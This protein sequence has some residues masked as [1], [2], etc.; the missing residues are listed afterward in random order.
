METTTKIFPRSRLQYQPPGQKQRSL[1]KARGQ[2]EGGVI[3]L[4]AA[5]K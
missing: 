2:G 1:R 4:G 3:C 5:E